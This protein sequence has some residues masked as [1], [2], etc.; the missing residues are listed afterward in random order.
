[1]A[2]SFTHW[3]RA[4]DGN[5]DHGFAHASPGLESWTASDA[6]PLHRHADAYAAVVL[7]GGYEEIGSNGRFQVT[8]GQVLLHRRFDAHFN[9]FGRTGARLLNMPLKT[10]VEYP[11]ATVDD[12]D[13][14][15]RMGEIDRERA[16]EL[17][18]QQLRPA[19]APPRDWPDLLALD[20]IAN[21]GTRLDEWARRRGLAPETV[22]RGFRKVFGV[23]PVAFRAEIRAQCAF[24]QILQAN[25]S[26]AEVAAD[27]CF[28]DQ[29]HM[30]RAITAM[31]GR[32]PGWWL[33]SI[34]FKSQRS[35]PS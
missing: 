11:F 1:M 28:A 19:A 25:S 16:S 30:S 6:T 35:L 12:P 21:P 23:S 33:R 20:L 18:L 32:P 4:A 26:L 10:D 13:A 2:P 17:L 5:P 34:R 27:A 31:T 14:I 8:A 9:R 24:T 15:A 7:S 3:P 22:S 29:A